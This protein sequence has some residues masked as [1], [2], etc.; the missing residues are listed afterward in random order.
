MG[1]KGRR[2]KRKAKQRESLMK[3]MQINSTEDGHLEHDF[4][5]NY[6]LTFL[7]ILNYFY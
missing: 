7:A 3:E 5:L 1:K 4:K 2:G 6:T